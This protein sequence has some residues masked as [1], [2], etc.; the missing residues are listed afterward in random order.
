MLGEY[1]GREEDSS[2]F[3]VADGIVSLT[4]ADHR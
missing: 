4:Q 1:A 2:V 3:S